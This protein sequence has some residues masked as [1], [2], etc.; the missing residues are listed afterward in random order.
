MRLRVPADARTDSVREFY[1]RS[2]FPG[3]PPSDDLAS[4]AGAGV[5]KRV[6]ARP[7]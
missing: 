6:R 3:Y 1:T 7:G 2:P 5:E 4:L